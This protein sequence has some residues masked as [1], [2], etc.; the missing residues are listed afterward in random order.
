MDKVGTERTGGSIYTKIGCCNTITRN[1]MTEVL[2]TPVEHVPPKVGECLEDR[3]EQQV[4]LLISDRGDR[5]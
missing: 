4:K 1:S 2:E 3:G 5:G